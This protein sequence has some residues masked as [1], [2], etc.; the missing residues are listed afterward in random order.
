MFMNR[1]IQFPPLQKLI[2]VY[3]LNQNAVANVLFLI[4]R[5]SSRDVMNV[6]SGGFQKRKKK[7]CFASG[8]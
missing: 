5:F 6:S 8:F 2:L 4:I 7:A 3:S 1:K